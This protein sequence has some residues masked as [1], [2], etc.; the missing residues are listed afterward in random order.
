MHTEVISRSADT[1]I[2]RQVLQPGEA[3]PWHIDLCHRF[4]V[5]VSGAALR[6]EFRD[7][8]AIDVSFAPGQADRDVPGYLEHRALN[9]GVVPFEE[10][11]TFRL[12][13]PAQD[14]QPQ[15]YSPAAV[16]QFWFGDLTDGFADAAHRA[17][18]FEPSAEF[19]AAIRTRFAELL[20]AVR[21]GELRGWLDA[22]DTCL[23]YILATDQF[24]RNVHRGSAEAFAT[25][26]LALQAARQGIAQG[27]DIELAPDQRSFFYLP[28]EHSEQ[29]LDQH[30]CVGLLSELRD[31]TAPGLRHRTGDYLR[32]A[33][34]H[35]D[36]IR[37]FGRFPH[38]NAVLGRT[39]T[40]AEAAFVA[41]GNS[42]GQQQQQP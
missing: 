33:H 22:A 12:E 42:F 32:Y 18:W 16:L 14:P 36:I 5:V 9:T 10:V 2:R 1:L 24:P 23:A 7:R 30:A 4:T 29:L 11:V 41:A 31:S 15:T 39:S 17:R 19:D 26:R 6:I 20:A 40:A 35:R 38:R 8:D 3:S 13:H 28:F 25:D 37:R 21:R 27:L 34:K